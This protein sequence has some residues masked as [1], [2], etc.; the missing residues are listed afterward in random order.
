MEYFLA[1]VPKL[2]QG[3]VPIPAD[4]A[5]SFERKG[6]FVAEPHIV[7][8]LDST[9]DGRYNNAPLKKDGTFAARALVASR[10]Q[11]DALG[12]FVEQKLTDIMERMAGGDVSV[13]PMKQ[14]I[15]AC[16]Y[17]AYDGICRFE[18]GKNKVSNFKKITNDEFF[19]SIV[20]GEE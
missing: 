12:H 17:C 5:D 14:G 16:Q 20:K 9:E 13:C 19:D 1:G 7:K 3:Q 8:A 10:E 4:L 11:M 15:N 18:F 2:E 6:L